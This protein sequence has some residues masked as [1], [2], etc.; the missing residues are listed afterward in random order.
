MAGNIGSADIAAAFASL[1]QSSDLDAKFRELFP[2][3]DAGVQ[4]QFLTLEDTTA[5]PGQPWPYCIYELSGP[6]TSA[7]MSGASGGLRNE[8]HD[9]PIKLSIYA[10]PI[11][12]DSRSEKEI[13]AALA[14]LV[15]GVYGGHPNVIPQALSLDNGGTLPVIYQNDAGVRVGDDEYLWMVNYL[16]RADIGYIA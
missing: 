3:A 7:R 2:A 9:Y 1:W 5:P 6:R 12:N 11:E 10:R 13:A 15:M 16:I 14:A 4:G 8:I